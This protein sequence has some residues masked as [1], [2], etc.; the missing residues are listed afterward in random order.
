MSTNVYA[1]V[2]T[3]GQ[4]GWMYIIMRLSATWRWKATAEEMPVC[5][6]RR[7]TTSSD[8]GSE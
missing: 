2:N 4:F 8:L 3:N 5:N 7:Q 6:L 1:Q